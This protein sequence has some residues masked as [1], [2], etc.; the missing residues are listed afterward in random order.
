MKKWLMS[1]VSFSAILSAMAQLPVAY[2]ADEQNLYWVQVASTEAS[3]QRGLMYRLYLPP[4]TG[5]LF[6]FDAPNPQTT[7]WMRNTMID[8]DMRFYNQ[9]GQ[10]LE[11]YRHVPPCTTLNCRFYPAIGEVKYVL[12]TS[13]RHHQVRPPFAPNLATDLKFLFLVDEFQ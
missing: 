5:M 7:F 12:E 3:R 10:L 11:H 6:I 9:Q 8:L 13:P 4:K 2:L 1:I